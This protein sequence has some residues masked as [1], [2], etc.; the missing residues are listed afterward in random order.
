MKMEI[1]MIEDTIVTKYCE[2][3]DNFDENKLD[4][5]LY[6]Y[7]NTNDGKQIKFEERT[8]IWNKICL[9]LKTKFN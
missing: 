6:E 9:K 5:F 7:Y 1:I 2:E 3:Y 8:Q 4:D